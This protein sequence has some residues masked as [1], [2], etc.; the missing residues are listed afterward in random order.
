MSRR[1][2]SLTLDNLD[3]LPDRCR[4]CVVW[5]LDPV[6]AAAA[7]SAGDPRLEK[8]AWISAT[9]LEWGSCG[10]IAYVESTPAGYALFAPPVLVPR[11]RAFPTSPV[12]SDAALLIT[13]YVQPEFA[14]GGIGRMLIQQVAKELIR[15]N[16][17]AIEAFGDL[18]REEERAPRV[19]RFATGGPGQ[20]LVE[21]LNP[22]DRGRSG[23]S[24][25]IPADFL[26]SVGFKTIRPHRRFPRMRLDLRNTITWR[27]DVEVALEK[28]LGTLTPEPAFRPI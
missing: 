26:L 24:C 7:I 5:E 9:L 23:G 21:P 4:R 6:A 12:A 13:A 27:E 10:A 15:R 19:R 1:L 28:L 11:S 18:R 17:R 16:V 3:D 22:V 25:V 2:E 20:H 8:E 14:G